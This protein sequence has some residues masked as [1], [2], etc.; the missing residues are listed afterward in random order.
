[1]AL[2]SL[3]HKNSPENATS[4]YICTHPWF[5]AICYTTLSLMR[6]LFQCSVDIAASSSTATHVSI[7]N[8]HSTDYTV[9]FTSAESVY[10][11]TVEPNTMPIWRHADFIAVK[12]TFDKDVIILHWTMYA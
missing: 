10:A 7:I 6:E 1:M 4:Q 9:L 12:S 11:F 2:I 8:P 5:R 3:G